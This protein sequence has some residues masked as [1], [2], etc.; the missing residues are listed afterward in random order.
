MDFYDDWGISCFFYVLLLSISI[1]KKK[2]LLSG[3]LILG[4][5]SLLVT[6]IVLSKGRAFNVMVSTGLLLAIAVAIL[7][8]S[9]QSRLFRTLRRLLYKVSLNYQQPK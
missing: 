3:V 4:L 9:Y 5:I 7:T 8:T 2:W 1:H 6:T